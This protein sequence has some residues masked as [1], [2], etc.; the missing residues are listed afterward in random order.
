[1]SDTIFS[2]PEESQQQTQEAPKQESQQESATPTTEEQNS[3]QQESKPAEPQPD[4]NSLFADQLAGIV[5]EDGRQKYADVQ[6]ALSSIPH[7]QEHIK[8]LTAQVNEL[9]E[10]LKQK[11]QRMDEVL[12]RIQPSQEVGEKPSNTEFDPAN[13]EALVEQQLSK[14]EQAQV[15]ERNRTQ[16]VSA[17]KEQFGE[18]APKKYEEKAKE[19]G[20]SVEV[21]NSL[22][23]Q[24]PAAVLAYF[25]GQGTKPSPS[26]VSG[27]VNTATLTKPSESQDDHMRIFTGGSN[28]LV[29]K[30][31]AVGNK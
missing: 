23:F 22:A 30:W 25:S 24:S 27:G 26:P 5:S 8:N 14:R 17:L 13:I 11:E 15:A 31:R 7:A 10:E 12:Q 21:L 3:P 16:V 4:P 29:N 28:D 9:R 20:V 1:M 19:L 6:T 18:D 2:N